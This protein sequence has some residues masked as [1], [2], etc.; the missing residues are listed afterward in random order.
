MVK[1]F[2]DCDFKLSILYYEPLVGM[3]GL[4]TPTNIK[5]D[6]ESQIK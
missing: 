4:G 1:L 2:A 3:K 6:P 5:S